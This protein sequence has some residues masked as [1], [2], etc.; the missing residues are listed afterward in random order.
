MCG[1][2]SF[3]LNKKEKAILIGLSPVL[4]PL[5]LV[6]LLGYGVFLGA[7]SAKA[8]TTT[9]IENVS[10][11]VHSSLNQKAFRKALQTEKNFVLRAAI[12]YELGDLRAC[13][14]EIAKVKQGAQTPWLNVFLASSC[15][16]GLGEYDRAFDLLNKCT[17]EELKE[18]IFVCPSEVSVPMK[19]LDPKYRPLCEEPY[20]AIRSVIFSL[21]YLCALG[22]AVNSTPAH[23]RESYLL[24]GNEGEDPHVSLSKAAKKKR[25]LQRKKELSNLSDQEKHA[26]EVL[27]RRK[28]S[29][30]FNMAIA[31]AESLPDG[32]DDERSTKAY[33]LA[34]CLY[35]A[36]MLTGKEK[37]LQYVREHKMMQLQEAK[38]KI[39]E[40]IAACGDNKDDDHW[41]NIC[42]L[43][44]KI[45]KVLTVDIDGE[46]KVAVV[47]D[48]SPEAAELF[49]TSRWP[50]RHTFPE[51]LWEETYFPKPTWCDL[52]GEF[53]TGVFSKQGSTCKHC[54]IVGH[55]AC[56]ASRGSHLIECNVMQPLTV[57]KH[58]RDANFERWRQL[59]LVWKKGGF[60]KAPKDVIRHI[61]SFM[62]P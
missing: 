22:V 47:T 49:T 24:H 41:Q 15:H 62:D 33:N 61:M 48:G 11:K 42:L 20:T 17:L 14:A 52:C 57:D 44:D 4:V 1:G 10:K 6:G 12:L 19:E 21:V 18:Y 56:V 39:A 46:G 13:L 25:I 27:L 58:R 51:H 26:A 36:A 32:T 55:A 28:L 53:I 9:G 34:M 37:T 31:L 30:L 29:D 43:Q 7:K 8:G 3:R 35:A 45:D 2:P 40:A 50:L 54:N 5:G 60:Q 23:L 16:V 38:E 59:M